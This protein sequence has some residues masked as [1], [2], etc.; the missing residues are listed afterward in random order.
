ML[1]KL[2]SCMTDSAVDCEFSVMNQDVLKKVSLNRNTEYK[3]LCPL[4][5]RVL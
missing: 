4:I 3:T 2:R 1:D 5:N